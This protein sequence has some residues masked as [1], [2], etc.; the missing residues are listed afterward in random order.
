MEL[1]VRRCFQVPLPEDFKEEIRSKI[2]KNED[3]LF[4]WS[5]VSADWED[6]E[7]DALLVMI[8]DM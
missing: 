1:M 3:V 6:G 7:G 8:I 2:L 5:L 4:Y